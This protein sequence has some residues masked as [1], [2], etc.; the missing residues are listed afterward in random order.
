MAGL[1]TTSDRSSAPS[2][3]ALAGAWIKKAA[4][5]P[6]KQR[7][8]EREVRAFNMGVSVIVFLCRAI[9][10]GLRQIGSPTCHKVQKM[11]LKY[12]THRKSLTGF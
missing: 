7:Q 11:S 10:P 12:E 4:S 1:R 3:S 8:A 6:V 9:L 5:S 2:N